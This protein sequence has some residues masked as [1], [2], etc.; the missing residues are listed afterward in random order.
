MPLF[1][2]AS[3]G[4]TGSSAVTAVVD[5]APQK[6]LIIRLIDRN[7][8]EFIFKGEWVGRDIM[9]IGRTIARA[10]RK[11]QLAKRRA[12]GTLVSDNQAGPTTT[13]ES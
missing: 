10:Y 5:I 9:L 1:K 12:Q 3:E 2:R 11:E 8:P 6:E 7:S 4:V 13:E